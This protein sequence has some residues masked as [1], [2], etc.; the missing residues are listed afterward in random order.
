MAEEPCVSHTHRLN[1]FITS[2][3]YV[4]LPE[5][6]SLPVPTGRNHCMQT[7]DITDRNRQRSCGEY[8]SSSHDTDMCDVETPTHTWNNEIE[9]FN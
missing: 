4:T 1:I 9:T 2:C 3:L 8:L 6:Q 5:E 7:A